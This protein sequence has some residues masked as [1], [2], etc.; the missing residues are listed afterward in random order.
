MN[1][2]GDSKKSQTEP[3][4]RILRGVRPFSPASPTPLISLLKKGETEDDY[5]AALEFLKDA[6]PGTV[7]FEL[8]S[9][10]PWDHKFMSEEDVKNLSSGIKFSTKAIER[11]VLRTGQRAPVHLFWRRTPPPS[12]NPR[13]WCANVTPFAPPRTRRTRE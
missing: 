11:L 9:L 6:S 7:D 2:D 4:S 10:G 8:R 5:A 1:A 12:W 13:T 3:K